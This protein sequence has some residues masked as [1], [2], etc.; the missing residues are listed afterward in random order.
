MLLVRLVTED[1][2]S[3]VTLPYLYILML[4]KCLYYNFNISS[5]LIHFSIPLFMSLSG[6]RIS[7]GSGT[8]I[9]CRFEY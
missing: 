8:R 5:F 7:I 9:K 6:Y 3:T 4:G 2:I 1:F